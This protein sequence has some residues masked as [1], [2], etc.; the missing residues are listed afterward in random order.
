MYSPPNLERMATL[1]IE[2]LAIGTHLLYCHSCDYQINN[3]AH[4]SVCPQCRGALYTTHVTQE[5]IDHC[6]Q[7]ENKADLKA[8]Q[9]R[10]AEKNPTRPISELWR[11]LGIESQKVMH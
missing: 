5:L 10:V 7:A 1:K 11:D 6:R 8:V 3:A 9:D 4:K 2:G